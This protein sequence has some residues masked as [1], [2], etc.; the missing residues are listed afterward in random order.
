MKALDTPVLLDLLR[1]QASARKLLQDL[2]AEE[3]G[4]TELN[5]FE[6]LVIAESGGKAGAEKRRAALA[7]LR[8]RLT[9]LPVDESTTDIASRARGAVLK[10]PWGSRL[11]VSALEAHGCL[12]WHTTRDAAPPGK[13]GRVYVHEYRSSPSKLLR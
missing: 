9:V 11:I 12:E 13:Y 5:M 1:Q 4:T 3:L 10:L 2:G 8:G 7:Q 6:L